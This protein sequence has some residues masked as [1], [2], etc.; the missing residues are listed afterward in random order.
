MVS[1]FGVRAGTFNVSAKVFV[2]GENASFTQ[3]VALTVLEP[4]AL[5]SPA[6]LLL[7]HGAAAAISTTFSNSEMD[8][9][10]EV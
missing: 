8:L 10:Y 5:L 7:P 4:L 9:K 2:L 1:V 3:W 6:S